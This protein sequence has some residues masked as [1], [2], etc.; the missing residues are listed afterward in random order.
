[1]GDIGLGCVY[2][3]RPGTL[4]KPWSM[5]A[6]DA[7]PDHVS[8]RIRNRLRNKNTNLVTIPC[9]MA[10]QLQPPHMSINKPFKHLIPKHYDA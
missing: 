6:M 1:M 9:S 8:K 5:L 2:E 4:S 3:H 10:S 7:F